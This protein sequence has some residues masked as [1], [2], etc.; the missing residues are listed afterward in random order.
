MQSQK[1]GYSNPP[2]S[3][4]TLVKVPAKT[5]PR[6]MHEGKHDHPITKAHI[7]TELS[8][9]RKGAKVE[10]QEYEITRK[11]WVDSQGWMRVSLKGCRGTSIINCTHIRHFEEDEK[12]R[13]WKERDDAWM[14]DYNQRNHGQYGCINDPFTNPEDEKIIREK[15]DNKV[16][17]IR[18]RQEQAKVE[19]EPEEEKRLREAFEQEELRKELSDNDDEDDFVSLSSGSGKDDDYVL[20]DEEEDEDD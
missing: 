4:E 10:H 12:T 13:T 19:D 17:R 14:R 9:K 2:I 20:T 5:S 15:I 6:R 3:R 7:A 18:V 11:W 16:R 1:Y 8:A